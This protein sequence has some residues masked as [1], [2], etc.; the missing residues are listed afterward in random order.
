MSFVLWQ[1]IYIMHYHSCSQIDENIMLNNL[2]FDCFNYKLVTSN[3]VN[4]C[5]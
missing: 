4:S 2:V 3:E 5:I 1:S